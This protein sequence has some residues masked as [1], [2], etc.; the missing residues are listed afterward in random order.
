MS[1]LVI[2]ESCLDVFKYGVCNRLCPEAPVP[3]FNPVNE[4]VNGGMAY[5]VYNNLLSLKV[6][7]EIQTNLNYEN[8]TKTRYIDSKANY[9]FMR[10]DE[11]DDQYPACSVDT[12]NFSLYEA[13]VIS[14]YNKGF[15]TTE[16]IERIGDSHPLVFLDTKKI[17]GDWCSSVTYIKINEDEYKKTQHTLEEELL[18]KL[19]ITMGSKGSRH[20][21]V[22]YPVPRVEIKD[23]SGAG[24]T[25]V[26][27][28]VCEYVKSRDIEMAIC[29]ANKNAT[30][31]VQKK[32][33]AVI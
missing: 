33:V 24:D 10:L 2:G 31:V 8:I 23:T 28:L 22:T 20:L 12:I 17:L 29:F 4:T 14:D 15:L 5:N 26:A 19:I 1:I 30:K 11:N 6:P 27:S 13:I 21:G 32:G 9:M 16:D 7:T 18:E 25:F 3:V